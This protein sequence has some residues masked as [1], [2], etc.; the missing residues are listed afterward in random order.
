MER[1]DEG[2]FTGNPWKGLSDPESEGSKHLLRVFV[3]SLARSFKT[4]GARPLS[5]FLLLG[6]SNFYREGRHDI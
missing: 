1:E 2:K 4:R 5:G 6:G 3:I